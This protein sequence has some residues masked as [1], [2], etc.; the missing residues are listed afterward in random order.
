MYKIVFHESKTTLSSSIGIFYNYFI[1][2]INFSFE[3]EDVLSTR[4]YVL[5]SHE[6]INSVTYNYDGNGAIY[7]DT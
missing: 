5:M 7:I 3:E 2:F 1:N 4:T 6:A